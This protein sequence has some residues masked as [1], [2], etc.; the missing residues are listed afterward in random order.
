MMLN[1]TAHEIQDKQNGKKGKRKLLSITAIFL[2]IIFF[3]LFFSPG[4]K[5]TGPFWIGEWISDNQILC[6]FIKSTYKQ[7]CPT[8]LSNK[9]LI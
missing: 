2:L 6:V 7:Y 4:V 8:V 9:N 3:G 5:V 1:S